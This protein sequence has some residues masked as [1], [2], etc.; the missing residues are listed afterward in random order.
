VT[1]RRTVAL[2]ATAA[3]LL[4]GPLLVSSERSDEL[5]HRRFAGPDSRFAELAGLDVHHVVAGEDHAGDD[6]P[7]VVLLHHFYGNTTT[8]RHVLAGLAQDAH[9]VAFDRPAFGLTDRPGRGEWSDGNPYTRERSARITLALL[10]HLGMERA[11]LVG[12]SAGGSAALESYA[13]APERVAGLVLVSPAITGDVGPPAALRGTLAAPQFRALAPT[14]ISRFSG[15]ITRQRISRSWADPSR[16]TDEDVAAYTLPQQVPGWELALYELFV[17]EPPPDL[18]DVLAR[19]DVPTV[20]VAGARDGV[21]SPATNRRTAAAIPTG[22]YVEIPDCGHTPQEECPDALIEV[23]RDV[24]AE[25]D[26]RG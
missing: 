22:R 24:L 8:W 4:G 25:A 20:V 16:A 5:A 13:L 6:A 3:L 14:F 9:A 1:R 7:G 11:V 10:D 12:S 26:R 17:A 15:D 21:I 19:I 23:I 2:A 18:R